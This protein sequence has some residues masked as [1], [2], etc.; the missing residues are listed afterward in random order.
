MSLVVEYQRRWPVDFLKIQDYILSSL[1]TYE[2]IEHIGSTSIPGMVAKPIIDI[3]IVV[4]EG[5][6][7]QVIKELAHLEYRHQGD[8]GVIG[9]EAFDYLPSHIDLPKHHLYA[10]YPDNQQLSGTRAFREFLR[11][12]EEWREKLSRLKLE[13][14]EKFA[15]N[16]KSYMDGKKELVEEI[17]GIA[18]KRQS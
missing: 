9:R 5:D 12:N 2:S 3:M 1:R 16:R 11:G 7:S 10:C 13:L 14:D 6:M 15:S 4:P 8:L 17:I 18:K